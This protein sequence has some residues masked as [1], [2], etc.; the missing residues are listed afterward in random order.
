MPDMCITKNAMRYYRR[1]VTVD[2]NTIFI[3]YIVIDL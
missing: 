3:K 1:V 2:K